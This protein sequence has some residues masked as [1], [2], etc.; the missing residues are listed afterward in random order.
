M[1]KLIFIRFAYQFVE[2]VFLE[3]VPISLAD[4]C[5]MSLQ[6]YGCFLV[7]NCLVFC[8]RIHLLLQEWYFFFQTCF[9][10]KSC[11][12]FFLLEL[13]SFYVLVR[14]FLCIFSLNVVSVTF[15]FRVK[16]VFILS[17]SFPEAEYQSE[18]KKSQIRQKTNIVIANLCPHSLSIFASRYYPISATLA[19]RR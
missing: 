5:L 14:W 6:Q 17:L 19:C 12:F 2:E 1:W 15:S 16:F 9:V 7:K 8:S 4:L 18:Q 13:T 10:G 11:L 3:F